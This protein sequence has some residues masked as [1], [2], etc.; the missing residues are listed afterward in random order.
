MLQMLVFVEVCASRKCLYLSTLLPALPGSL[1][2]DRNPPAHLRVFPWEGR[3]HC[4]QATKGQRQMGRARAQTWCQSTGPAMQ[5]MPVRAPMPVLP[6]S[7]QLHGPPW[8]WCPPALELPYVPR[9]CWGYCP[10]EINGRASLLQQGLTE[11]WHWFL[12]LLYY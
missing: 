1:A 3:L 4:L 6:S 5:R 9:C 8:P 12:T 2:Q 10:Q 7:L 11:G